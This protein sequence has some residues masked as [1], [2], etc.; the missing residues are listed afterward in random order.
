MTM[1]WGWNGSWWWSLVMSG[2]MLLFW[3]FVAWFV[4]QSIRASSRRDTATGND[5]ESTL[6]ARFAR[7]E[8]DA[9]EYQAR[10]D[11]L[12]GSRGPRAA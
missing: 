6:A 3:G 12:R 9:K 2:G 1:M 5:P 4:V 11:V 8:I 10:L 7:G